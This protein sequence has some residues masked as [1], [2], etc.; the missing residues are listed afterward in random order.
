M[1]AKNRKRKSY[2]SLLGIGVPTIAIVMLLIFSGCPTEYRDWRPPAPPEVGTGAMPATPVITNSGDGFAFAPSVNLSNQAEVTAAM[3][4]HEANEPGGTVPVIAVIWTGANTSHFNIYWSV[5]PM[6]P[7]EPQIRNIPGSETIYYIRVGLEPDTE[8]FVWVEAVNA[9]GSVLSAPI[10]RTTRNRGGVGTNSA[11]NTLERMDYPRGIGIE[12]GDGQLT[13]WWNLYSRIGWNEVYVVRV[14]DRVE[15]PAPHPQAGSMH[16]YGVRSVNVFEPATFANPWGGG[17]A[18]G[19]H[20]GTPIWPWFSWGQ[21]RGWLGYRFGSEDAIYDQRQVVGISNL[22][23]PGRVAGGVFHP[24]GAFPFV[25]ESW[26]EGDPEGPAG[27]LG[28]LVPY[29]PI[30][31]FP[32]F[33]AEDVFAWNPATGTATESG[34]A[35]AHWA[36]H[37]TITGLQNGEEYEIWIRVPNV[38]GERGFGVIRGR[39][40]PATAPAPTA[41]TVTAPEGT[42][43]NLLVS[44]NPVDGAQAYRVFYSPFNE[45]PGPRT[46]FQRVTP[47]NN[48]EGRQ[49]VTLLGLMPNTQYFLWV[50]AEQ[51][52]VAGI[53][54]GM[55]TG[56]TG[57][58]TTG[59]MRQRLDVNGFPVR[60]L[61]YVEVNDNNIL[62]AGDY[63]LEDGTFL[64]DYIVIFAANLRRRD[65]SLDPDAAIHGCTISGVHIHFNENVRH[66][67]LNRSTFI[68]PLQDKGIRV[69]LG[70][71]G[72]WDGIGFGSMNAAEIDAMVRH[73]VE[74]ME[75][76]DLDGVDFDDEWSN[77]MR[78]SPAPGTPH[79]GSLADWTDAPDGRGAAVAVYPA[80]AFGWPFGNITVW[81]DP[82][83]GIN[84]GNIVMA[85]PGAAY[86]NQMW[87]QGG[88]NFYETIRRTRVAFNE[89]EPRLP[90]RPQD[91]AYQGG[92]RRL[93]ISLYEF[94]KARWVTRGLVASDNVNEGPGLTNFITM[95][96]A[97]PPIFPPEGQEGVNIRATAESLAEL[98]DFFMQ[99]WYN[100]WHWDSPNHIPRRQF[101]PLAIDVSGH[102]YAGQNN[103]PN[104]TFP[105]REGAGRPISIQTVANRFRAVSD[106]AAGLGPGASPFVA[107]YMA[108]A[109]IDGQPYGMMFFYN[110]RPA[111][112]LLSETPGGPAIR[113]VEEY[114]SYLTMTVFGQRTILTVGGGDRPKGF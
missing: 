35:I 76:Y 9:N 40:G 16:R 19:N 15:L 41:P 91:I 109:P 94:N 12:P 108:N 98:V 65:C 14:R 21:D 17:N 82:R 38:W 43:R 46:P 90:I 31:S 34:V 95:P 6:R 32:Q 37:A 4:L 113:T 114:L 7:E 58:P 30:T 70:L 86:L 22:D 72:D 57:L 68:Q 28:R 50:A 93:T 64:F 101:S 110:L 103:S 112:M 99:P 48:N 106:A 2:F 11:G 74:I 62:N 45:P 59:Q 87:L 26:R 29:R 51:D 13:V 24:S 100:Q 77:D 69:K 81:R 61:M 66:I 8:Y 73:I 80:H 97:T 20:V 39:P 60:T 71:L 36:N 88:R 63:I 96:D 52:G 55:I 1:S 67:L 79:F 102:A 84:P 47:Q 104:P 78:F 3:A 25:F 10:N 23:P 33:L 75:R 105:G 18:A 49:E 107:Q 42:T 83:D 56:T 92:V 44:W 54:T 111:S 85:T 53:P 5:W 27:S 89:L